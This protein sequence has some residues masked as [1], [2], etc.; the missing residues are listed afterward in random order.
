[1][2]AFVAI[3]SDLRS[4]EWQDVDEL[5]RK[6]PGRQRFL[7]LV[8]DEL[9]AE[10]LE[11]ERDLDPAV[12][13]EVDVAV[14][15]TTSE[16]VVVDALTRPDD[17]AALE[18][19]VEK[20]DPPLVLRELGD[21][22][23]A[24]A[25]KQADFD[26]VL[27]AD[28]AETLDDSDSY[29]EAMGKLEDDARRQGL[30]PRAVAREAVPGGGHRRAA[31]EELARPRRDRVRPQQRC[32]R[33]VT[34]SSWS[35]SGAAPAMPPSTRAS[36]SIASRQ[37]C[38]RSR[39]SRAARSVASG[40]RR[41]GPRH[42]RSRSSSSRSSSGSRS[43]TSSRLLEGEVALYVREGAPIP[44]ATL[45]AEAAD[46][47]EAKRV[48]DDVVDALEPD[49]KGSADSDGVAVTTASFEGFTIRYGTFR[50]TPSSSR[51][52]RNGIRDFRDDGD[53]L[54]DDP[55]YEDASEAAGDAGRPAGRRSTS[56]S[57]G[58]DPLIE[59]FAALR[60]ASGA[61]ARRRKGES[62]ARSTRCS[63]GASATATS[64]R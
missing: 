7:T 5:L 14:A 43:A 42:E 26:R 53:R 56:T 54:D 18:R 34:A 17:P 21:G 48:V 32:P 13:A 58:R 62:L 40:T 15:G 23:H 6:F 24:V 22:W 19:L 51:A 31:A 27:A 9:R 47:A 45:V 4:E 35:A 38:S 16:D 36:C 50:R 2:T 64:R 63:C 37:A 52:S 39:R 41:R 46:E 1:M 3:D 60:A 59:D 44:E 28:G 25:E 61:P 12:G 8:Q 11:W 20:E 49:Q 30:P 55:D 57:G 33:R 10:E 29:D